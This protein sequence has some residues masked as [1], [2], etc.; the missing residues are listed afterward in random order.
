[1]SENTGRGPVNFCTD[2]IR[3][4][5]PLEIAAVNRLKDSAARSE[6]QTANINNH[7]PICNSG[8]ICC[9]GRLSTVLAISNIRMHRWEGLSR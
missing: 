3:L 5:K 9:F 1:V 2:Q 4:C 7:R 8:V 6:R